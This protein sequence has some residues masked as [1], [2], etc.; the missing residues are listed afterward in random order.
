[1]I[2]L[3]FTLIIILQE[4]KYVI[5]KMFFLNI[6]NEVYRI[7]EIFSHLNK[8]I[9]ILCNLVPLNKNNNNNMPPYIVGY[10]LILKQIK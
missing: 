2:Y 3:F 1:M 6:G 4:K 10:L 7:V 8:H 9:I 5:V